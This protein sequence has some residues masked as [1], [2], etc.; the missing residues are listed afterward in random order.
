MKLFSIK[1]FHIIGLTSFALILALGFACKKDNIKND[2][3]L[4]DGKTVQPLVATADINLI[5]EGKTIDF[6]CYEEDGYG[7][8]INH[9]DTALI[10]RFRSTDKYGEEIDGPIV[11]IYINSIDGIHQGDVFNFSTGSKEIIMAGTGDYVASS[12]EDTGEVKITSL[13]GKHIEGTFTFTARSIYDQKAVVSNGKFQY[14]HYF[15]Q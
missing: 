10:L 6:K 1:P 5:D 2:S 9:G 15:I 3:N 14:D 8:V 7:E 13:S 4:N 12:G 11:S